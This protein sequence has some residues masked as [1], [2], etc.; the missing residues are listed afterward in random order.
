MSVGV[1]RRGEGFHADAPV[2]VY[3]GGESD[4]EFRRV[5][6]GCGREVPS[7]A[8][9]LPQRSPSL[10]FR[11]L[12]SPYA[13]H[14]LTIRAYGPPIRAYG[15]R[16]VD[17]YPAGSAYAPLPH[18]LSGSFRA[19]NNTPRSIRSISI[20][21]CTIRSRIYTPQT[22]RPLGPYAPG[23]PYAPDHTHPPGPY[24]PE[25][26]Y[27]PE[28]TP[29]DHTPRVYDVYAGNRGPLKIAL[30]NTTRSVRALRRLP[31]WRTLHAPPLQT[32]HT[33]R[34]YDTARVPSGDDV[35][36]RCHPPRRHIGVHPESRRQ[37]PTAAVQKVAAEDDHVPSSHT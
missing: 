17:V 9:K 20:R 37:V 31:T 29:L 14:T 22:I 3:G 30:K 23:R 26:P 8:A 27:A 28:H 10:N 2:R 4:R 34:L 16:M 32:L 19:V 5:R 7:N 15:Q 13:D 25:R 33:Q 24:A 18:L 21:P 6:H 35:P 36:W 11:E 12:L 1:R